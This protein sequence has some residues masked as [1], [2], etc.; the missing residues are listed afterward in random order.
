MITLIGRHKLPSVYPFRFFATAGGL[1]SYGP[2][3]DDELRSTAG[4]VDRILRGEKPGDLPVQA[5]TKY[6]TGDQSQDR[7][8]IWYLGAAAIARTRR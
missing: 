5:P 4:Y 6:Q 7:E 2:N 3:F 8:G 1:I